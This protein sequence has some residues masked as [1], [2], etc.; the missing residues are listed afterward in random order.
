M[1]KKTLTAPKN[2]VKKIGTSLCPIQTFT[3]AD[4]KTKRSLAAQFKVSQELV[5]KTLKTLKL[6]KV[7]FIINGHSSPVVLDEAHNTPR[8]HP[9]AIDIFETYLNQ[10]K[11]K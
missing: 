8:V 10:E 9:M 7:K 11:A 3:K 2:S 4:Y 1:I 5:E 6:K